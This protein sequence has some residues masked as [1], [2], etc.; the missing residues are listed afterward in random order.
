LS[1]AHGRKRRGAIQ[2]LN[3]ALFVHAQNQR[4]VGRVQVETND[5]ADFV[6]EPRVAAQFESLLR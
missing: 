3:L 2:R 4:S 5:V 1:R 6:D